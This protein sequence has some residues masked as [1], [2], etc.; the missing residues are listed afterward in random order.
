MQESIGEAVT[1]GI[2]LWKA[3]AP[4]ALHSDYMPERPERP[5]RRSRMWAAG[6]RG[7]DS[8]ELGIPSEISIYSDHGGDHF[9]PNIRLEEHNFSRGQSSN[10]PHD[11]H[12]SIPNT[13]GQL[14]DILPDMESNDLDDQ[15]RNTQSDVVPID[16]EY[17]LEDYQRVINLFTA[18]TQEDKQRFYLYK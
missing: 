3:T 7:S 6:S 15:V 5:E 8:S 4:I 12:A 13:D 17:L 9:E 14:R 16:L 2:R 11:V 1:S 10:I 18:E